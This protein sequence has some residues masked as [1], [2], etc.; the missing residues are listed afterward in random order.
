MDQCRNRI[1]ISESLNQAA[2]AKTVPT[3]ETLT[4]HRVERVLV[5]RNSKATS[6]Y[7]T[8]VFLHVLPPI[9]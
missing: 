8:S 7:V 5:I 4:L 3:L 6:Y 2:L 9:V 1:L